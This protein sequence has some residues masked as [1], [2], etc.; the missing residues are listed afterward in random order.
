[1]TARPRRSWS[2][3]M[4]DVGLRLC[5]TSSPSQ[6]GSRR[7]PRAG[8]LPRRAPRARGLCR[9]ASLRAW[10]LGIARRRVADHYR[11]VVRRDEVPA[12]DGEDP[13]P[14]TFPELEADLDRSRLRARAGEVLTTLP[15]PYA[16][17][18]MWRY[19]QERASARSQRRPVGR[20]RPSSACWR[21]PGY[22]SSA[23]G[24]RNKR[25]Q[26]VDPERF[27]ERLAAQTADDGA[28]VDRASARLKSRVYS[29]LVSAQAA[30]RPLR[31]L[32]DTLSGRR[33]VRVRAPGSRGANRRR[34]EGQEPVPCL[35]RP[36][37]W[38]S[39]SITRPSTGRT[40]HTRSS[41]GREVGS[42]RD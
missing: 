17:V 41:T 24:K 9:R 5:P 29:A 13:G 1:M 32:A 11:M 26:A 15:D 4:R 2:H 36:A 21:A 35:S 10:I 14:V 33:A 34:P 27:F 40:V 16:F 8:G 12:D 37:S 28:D 6:S 39:G 23:N 22:S 42:E 7:G 18:L 38:E 20:R 3:V 25:G 30:R 31:S 19:W